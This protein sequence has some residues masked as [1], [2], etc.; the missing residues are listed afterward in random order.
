MGVG[1]LL[2]LVERAGAC[3]WALARCASF[4]RVAER[5]HP[6]DAAGAVWAWRRWR[7]VLDQALVWVVAGGRLSW[8]LPGLRPRSPCCRG[9]P[10]LP[11]QYFRHASP[12][13]LESQYPGLALINCGNNA[14]ASFQRNILGAN[15]IIF[16]FMGFCFY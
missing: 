11:V 15:S 14:F 9:P 5:L 13:A 6:R 10:L 12:A 16:S 2:S 1:G 4:P 3:E 8:E 7:A